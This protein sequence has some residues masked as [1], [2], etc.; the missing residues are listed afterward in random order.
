MTANPL[1]PQ[2][3]E[4]PACGCQVIL[5]PAGHVVLHRGKD[6]NHCPAS[7]YHPHLYRPNEVYDCQKCGVIATTYAVLVHHDMEVHP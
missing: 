3:V 2:R 7:G 4:C 1:G 5:A 6:T